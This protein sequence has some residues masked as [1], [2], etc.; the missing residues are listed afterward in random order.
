MHPEPP[1][2]PAPLDE[3]VGCPRRRAGDAARS[4]TPSLAACPRS[5]TARGVFSGRR[6]SPG[7]TARG[8]FSDRRLSP[9]RQLVGLIVTRYVLELEPVA[10]ASVDRLVADIAPTIQRYLTG[11]LPPLRETAQTSR[12]SP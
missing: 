1:R 12:K 11:P 6:L 9:G 5:R 2:Q 10:S 3:Q 8:V 7:R 4:G